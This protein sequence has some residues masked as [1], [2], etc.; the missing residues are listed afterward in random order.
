MLFH[1]GSINNNVW[2]VLGAFS[3]HHLRTHLRT[4]IM[5]KLFVL[6]GLRTLLKNLFPFTICQFCALLMHKSQS[7]YNRALPT[8]KPGELSP[9][10]L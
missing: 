2:Q 7:L 10:D 5:I 8:S 4:N 1:K 6:H 9:D 3:M